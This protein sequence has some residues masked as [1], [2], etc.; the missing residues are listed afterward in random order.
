VVAKDLSGALEREQDTV[1]KYLQC[2]DAQ[3]QDLLRITARCW[4]R[5]YEE[6]RDEQVRTFALACAY[7][8][9]RERGVAL[10]TE[11][12]TGER[13]EDPDEPRIW[14]EAMP[15]P[16]LKREGNTQIDLALGTITR[17]KDTDSG[18]EIEDVRAPWV[19][20]TEMKWIRD[21]SPETR[22]L[23]HRNQLLRVIE[24]ALCFQKN[25]RC[26]ERVYVTLV[27]PAFLLSAPVKSRL[28]H[29]KYE[30]YSSD[31]RAILW[32][33]MGTCR[34]EEHRHEPGWYYPSS[35]P[36][37]IETLTLRWV[38]YDDLFENIPDSAIQGQV[39]EFWGQAQK[40]LPTF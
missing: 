5:D 34:T 22:H 18:I 2:S 20:M 39:Q 26:A 17:R 27:T 12:F 15:V 32:D 23:C 9:A 31:R 40:A 4:E 37:R 14:L 16:P 19:C 25:G 10:L 30:E 1:R 7:A 3:W 13:P 24:N 11:L 6:Q 36:A 35:M 21:I 33:L 29:Y 8:A 38:T 28:Y